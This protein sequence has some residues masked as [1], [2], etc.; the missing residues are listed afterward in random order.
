MKSEIGQLAI[1]FRR[2][3]KRSWQDV[4]KG[5]SIFARQLKQL[6]FQ[7]ENLI[8]PENL[9]KP[10]GLKNAPIPYEIQFNLSNRFDCQDWA[11]D[12]NFTIK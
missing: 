1:F 9:I 6:I 8:P 3:Q 4:I 12:N 7:E 5:Q 2:T 11:N 10:I